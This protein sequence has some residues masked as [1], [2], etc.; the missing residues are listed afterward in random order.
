[1][2]KASLLAATALFGG[3]AMPAFAQDQPAVDLKPALP[4]A[5]ASLTI[6]LNSEG[7]IE[8]RLVTYQ[9]DDEQ[10][11]GVHYVNAAPNFLAIVPVAGQDLVFATT[12][13]ASGARYV[14][15]PYEWWS[16]QGEATLRDVMQDEDAPPLAI[17]T[18]TSN[19]P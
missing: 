18:E 5:T 2:A 7:D 13:S 12:V 19:T 8:R 14:S 3:L 10:V 9:C 6:L 1:M 16:H 11:L 4:S 17:C 15:G